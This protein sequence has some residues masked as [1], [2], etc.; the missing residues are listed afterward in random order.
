MK[1]QLIS[2]EDIKK[3]H[4]IFQKSYGSKL[5]RFIIRFAGLYK[6]NN[7]YDSTKHLSGPDVENKMIEGLGIK[8]EVHNLEVIDQFKG[9]PFITVSNHPY[10]H[11]DGIMLIGSIAE[12]RSDFRVMVNWVLGY[13]DTMA[14]HF[15]GVNPYQSGSLSEKSSL[16]GVKECIRH[17]KNG[18]S[19]GFFPAGAISKNRIFKIEDRDWQPS[20]LKLIQKAKV[21]VVPV[22]ISGNNSL[23]FNIL[24]LISWRLRSLRLCHELTNKKGKS[25]HLVFGKAIM[26]EELANYQTT[27]ELG[28]FL[29][30]KTYELKKGW[31]K[32][33]DL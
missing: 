16:S 33:D 22:F 4:P 13:I 3:T 8:K 27:E 15:I 31:K 25:I 30:K 32:Q 12:K 6:A 10:G 17:I 5:A 1:D 9:K 24:D 21:P 14:D 26:P 7:A 11:I 28:I 19:L 20:V 23:F 2:I 18:D 29:K